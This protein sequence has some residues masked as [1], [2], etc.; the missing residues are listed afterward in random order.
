MSCFVYI[1]SNRSKTLY[2]GATSDLSE[3]VHQHKSKQVPGFTARYN[4]DRLV[5]AEA[6]PD[7]FTAIAREKQIKGWRRERKLALVETVNPQ[8]EDLSEA[9]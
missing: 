7:A 1:M 9:W 5:Y 6:A 8:W 2:T 4:I 3:R